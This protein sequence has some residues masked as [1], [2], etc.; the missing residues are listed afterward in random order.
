MAYGMQIIWYEWLSPLVID[1]FFLCKAFF[2]WHTLNEIH[3]H[4]F[5]SMM[6]ANDTK[7]YGM[8]DFLA[9]W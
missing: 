8:L 2:V 7:A 3:F 1:L 9:M 5:A 6:N 4:V